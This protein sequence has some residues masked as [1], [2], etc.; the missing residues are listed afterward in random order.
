MDSKDSLLWLLST[1]NTKS[2][3]FASIVINEC[4]SPT[5]Q[6]HLGHCQVLFLTSRVPDI[7]PNYLILDGNTLRVELGPH[8]WEIDLLELPLH[9]PHDQTG[10]SHIYAIAQ[11][12]YFTCPKWPLWSRFGHP[13][14]TCSFRIFLL[15]NILFVLLSEEK[16]EEKRI[17]EKKYP[18][19]LLKR[20]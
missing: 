10:F 13:P 9:V 16:E 19:L 2:A 17:T 20:N 14:W 6:I 11:V 1:S 12:V 4:A 8:R 5:S 7:Q 18:F 3:T 15:I